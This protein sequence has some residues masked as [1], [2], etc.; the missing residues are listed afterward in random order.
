MMFLTY[1]FKV[2]LLLAVSAAIIFIVV[3]ISRKKILRI[4]SFFQ[5]QLGYMLVLISLLAPLIP[6]LEIRQLY[7]SDVALHAGGLGGY[8][9]NTANLFISKIQHST[10]FEKQSLQIILA[11]ILISLF[12]GLALVVLDFIKICVLRNGSRT[13][14]KIGRTQ[15]LVHDTESAPSSFTIWR[16]SYAVLPLALLHD[17]KAVSHSIKH[18][19]QHIR[20]KDTI[21]IY[22]LVTVQKCL[23]LNPAVHFLIRIIKDLQEVACDEKLILRKKVKPKEYAQTLLNVLELKGK[24]NFSQLAPSILGKNKK[25]ELIRRIHTMSSIT[26]KNNI[27]NICMVFI[28][29]TGVLLLSARYTQAMELKPKENTSI[30]LDMKVIENGKNISRP[31]VIARLGEEALVVIKAGEKNSPERYWKINSNKVQKNGTE[32]LQIDIEYG[33]VVH[34]E[35]GAHLDNVYM[36]KGNTQMMDNWDKAMGLSGVSM[37]A[38]MNIKNEDLVIE[39][40]ALPAPTE[41]EF[42]KMILNKKN[43]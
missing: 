1:Y 42:K 22:I 35:K 20:Q 16:S 41:A 2:N 15:I 32:M 34:P 26:A 10:F 19:L 3:H 9:A 30:L 6:R 29:A 14:I 40:Q 13:L 37:G 8:T 28:F 31:K 38:R 7:S 17:S 11:G 5:L 27:K 12:W 4:P 33:Q 21:W 39:I 43:I 18:E 23:L 25:K 36:A 24:R